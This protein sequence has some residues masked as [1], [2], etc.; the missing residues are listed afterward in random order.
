MKTIK[1]I[2]ISFLML[3]AFTASISAQ[4]DKLLKWNSS[5]K[6]GTLENGMSYYVLKNSHPENRI[7]LRLVVKAG[8]NMEE[9]DQK[10]VAHFV[11]HMCFNGTENFKKSAIVDYFESIGMAF[12]P[13]VNAYTSFEETVYMLEIP[14]DNPEIL[15]KSLQVLRDWACSV[16]FEQEELDKERGVIKEEWRINQGVSGRIRDS[17]VELIL[18]DSKYAERLPIG[19]MKIIENISRDR[20]VDFYQK[21]YRPEFMSIVAVGDINPSVL[22]KEIKNTMN[23]ISK[24]EEMVNHPDFLVP[25]SN[26][27]VIKIL[28]DKEM[29]NC[30]VDIFSRVEDY[31]QIRTEAQYRE[32]ISLTLFTYIFNQRLQ[33]ITNSPDAVWLLSGSGAIDYSKTS[34][35]DY[36]NF[37]PKEG[38][39]IS[40]IKKM[41]DEYTRICNFGITDEELDRVKKLLLSNADLTLKNKNNISSSDLASQIVNGILYNTPVISTDNSVKLTKKFVNQITKE[42]ILSDAQKHFKENGNRMLILLPENYKEKVSEKEILDIWK[43]YQNQEIENYTENKIKSSLMDKP[44][45]KGKIISTEKNSN[46]GT[47]EY[48]FEN[49]IKLICKKT[50]YEKDLIRINGFSRFG[51]NYFSEKEFPSSQIMLNYASLSGFGDFNN[52]ELQKLLLDKQV[53]LNFNIFD[54]SNVIKGSS[55]NKD[56]EVLLQLI[57]LSFTKPR[58][59]LHTKF[60]F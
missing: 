44:A 33:E 57:N 39:L 29:P 1:K 15:T 36:V 46:L 28:K 51:S 7:L 31:S 5:I 24:S 2:V 8:S 54:T 52:V 4:N 59:T 11:E 17:L 18:K 19:D 10:G 23:V 45:I 16:T 49:G 14:A 20:V 22:E 34:H 38:Q 41:I 27:K 50:K 43:N 12:G 30:E 9:D 37:V 60:C 21:W 42:E 25:N 48:T 40:S 32:N 13:E 58:F 3:F 35:Y 47:T 6:N 53:S 56:F 26:E 55:N